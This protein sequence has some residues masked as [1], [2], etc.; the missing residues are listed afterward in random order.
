VKRNPYNVSLNPTH[1]PKLASRAN[2]G[3]QGVDLNAAAAKRKR[4]KR[5]K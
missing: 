5:K 1:G 2:T 3:P 4:R